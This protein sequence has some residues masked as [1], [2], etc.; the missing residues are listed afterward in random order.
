MAD[1]AQSLEPVQTA[2]PIPKICANCK[3]W[4]V[5]HMSPH[6]G[7]CLI[8][9]GSGPVPVVTTDLTKCGAFQIR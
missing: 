3:N 4:S 2:P 8:S 5:R 1:A 6:F 9:R 7:D